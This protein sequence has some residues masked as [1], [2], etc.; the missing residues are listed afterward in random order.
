MPFQKGKSG[1][2]GGRPKEKPFRDA[3]RMEMLAAEKGSPCKATKGSLRWN[4]RQLL[5]KGDVAS[6]REL[7]D[8][9][10]GKVPQAIVGDDDHAP[11]RI[12]EIRRVIVQ[13]GQDG[14]SSGDPPPPT[15]PPPS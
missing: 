12:T 8:R 11:V 4:A 5:E 1:N 15:A 7:A 2:P 9:L 3:L 10:D 13:P 6:I 14:N